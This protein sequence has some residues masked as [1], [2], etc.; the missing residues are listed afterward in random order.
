MMGSN[1]YEDEKP[2]HKVTIDYEFDMGKYP[3]TVAEYMHF[4]KETKREDDRKWKEKEYNHPIISVSW[5]DAK[6]YCDWLSEKTGD[7]YR[8]PTEAEWEYACRAGTTTKWSFGDDEEELEKYAW[9]R[10]NSNRTTH[11][12]GEKKP[13]PWGLYDMH[14]NV[15]EWCEDWYDEDKDTKVLRGGSWN[16]VADYTRS[17]SRFRYIPGGRGY[18]VGV[19]LLRTLPS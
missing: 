17:A 4:V 7:E 2:I 18:S 10:E 9:Y 8:L 5:H 11:P 12:V 15:W 19:R 6:A 14:G 13:N 1:E 3:V 16:N